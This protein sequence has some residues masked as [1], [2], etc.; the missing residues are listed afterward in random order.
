MGPTRK[1][2]RTKPPH[3]EDVASPPPP[4]KDDASQVT[5]PSSDH[6]DDGAT[7]AD[8]S[9]PLKETI[10][11]SSST[12]TL[13]SKSSWYGTWPRKSKPSTQVARESILADKSTNTSSTTASPSTDLSRYESKRSL[14]VTDGR[15]PSMYLGKSKET[16]DITMGGTL[17]AEDT[18]GN[19]TDK[20]IDSKQPVSKK[21][22]ATKELNQPIQS[23]SDGTTESKPDPA[24]R[25]VTSSGWLGGW[26]GKPNTQL[27]EAE[28]VSRDPKAS[29]PSEVDPQISQHEVT[30]VEGPTIVTAPAQTSSWFGLWST[31]APSS[32]E[33]PPKELPVK[34]A[35]AKPTKTKEDGKE[36]KSGTEPVAGSSWAFWSTDATKKG[37]KPEENPR[38]PGELAVTGEA[39]QSDPQPAKTTVIKDDDKKGKS[40]KRG[41]PISTDVD[42]PS[43]KIPQVEP[44]SNKATPSQS[45][46]SAKPSPPNLLLP[47]VKSTYH[48][49][50]NPSILQQITRLLIHGQQK[51]VKHVFLSKEPPKIKKAL[52]IG[53]HGL[54]PAPLLRT[55][56]GQPTGTSIRF[57]NHAA[58]AIRRWSDQHGH[59]DCEIEKVALEGEGKIAERVDNLWKLLLNWIDHVRKADFIMIACHS[60]GVPVALMLVAKLIEFGVVSTGRIGVCAMG[61]FLHLEIVP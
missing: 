30:P 16:S 59:V 51:P 4:P 29:Q 54:F 43:K 22:V 52:A 55:V 37:D 41:R 32:L 49:V 42:E 21:E 14:P 12:Q 6:I 8:V 53:I 48:L 38:G 15:P 44:V 5:Q 57:A 39:S 61:K 35:D 28:E 33:E 20:T 2:A 34:I 56:I 10:Q 58:A 31:A 13:S 1:R 47:S 9:T 50:E 46:A 3:K 7:E 11:G 40:T 17:E 23:V 24:Q 45:P 60:Q 36:P 19:T 27:P 26:L 18:A 25:P